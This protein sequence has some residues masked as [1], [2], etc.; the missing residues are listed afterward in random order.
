ML[1]LQKDITIEKNLVLI[2][3]VQ[4]VLVDGFSKKSRDSEIRQWSGRTATNKIV[5]FTCNNHNPDPGDGLIGELIQVR[6]D[7]VLPNSLCGR[8]TQ[9]SI[10]AS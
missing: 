5:N 7:E 8:M 4:V 10:T 2:D 1:R 9:T 3:S 6:I